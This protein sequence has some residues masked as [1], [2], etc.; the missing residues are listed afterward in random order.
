MKKIMEV[1]ESPME[2]STSTAQS[3]KSVSPPEK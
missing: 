2:M 3:L 1:L